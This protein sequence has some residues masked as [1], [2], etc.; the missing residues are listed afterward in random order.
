[1]NVHELL[2]D[3]NKHRPC[4]S[5]EFPLAPTA[6][7]WMEVDVL[8]ERA[9]RFHMRVVQDIASWGTVKV[10]IEQV[11]RGTPYYAPESIRQ[12]LAELPMPATYHEF[13]LSKFSGDSICGFAAGAVARRVGERLEQ[14]TVGSLELQA[15]EF[16][17]G[18]IY[19]LM[20]HPARII[21]SLSI[22]EE[23]RGWRGLVLLRDIAWAANQLERCGFR[24]PRM[25]YYGHMWD[26][27]LDCDY[28]QCTL[29]AKV[30]DSLGLLDIR[31]TDWID[32]YDML[33]V[34]ASQN[35]A[36][37]IE[38]V[39]PVAMMPSPERFLVAALM[40]PHIQAD[41]DGRCGIVHLRAE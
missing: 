31:M 4:R 28:D 34:E 36:R 41:G 9:A 13:E 16:C 12:L 2:L 37:M 15:S 19:G 3:P 40:V 1:M 21:R 14:M 7:E 27:Y 33:L 30:K 5:P 26:R 8:V 39:R 24:G 25:L 29:R 22:P 17:S 18:K 32:G 11:V 35:T 38:V 20:N 10:G 6:D 23:A